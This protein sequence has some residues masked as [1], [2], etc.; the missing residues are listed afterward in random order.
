[1]TSTASKAASPEE[2]EAA[3]TV[4]PDR[5]EGAEN[6]AAQHHPEVEADAATNSV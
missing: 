6:R 2:G 3:E 1:M 5:A 4:R